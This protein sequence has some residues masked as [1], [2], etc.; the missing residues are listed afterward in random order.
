MT[1]NTLDEQLTKYLTDVHSI[2]EQALIQ[3]R[4]APDIAADPQLA[5][6][7]EQHCHETEGQERAVRDR[8]EARDAEPSKLKDLPGKAGGLAFVLFARS[9]PD[10]AGKLTTH[11]FSYEAMELAAYELLTRV[12]DRAGD[13]ET[14]A[15]AREIAA[16]EQ[17]MMD[18][19]EGLF[20]TAVDASLGELEPDDLSEQLDKYLSD[21]HAIEAQAIELLE[22]GPEIAGDEQIA[23]LYVEHLRETREHQRLVAER[24]EARGA[25]P[26]NLKDAAMRMGALNWGAF[27][28]AQP[29]TPGKLVAFAYAFEHLEIGAYEQLRRVAARA[30]DRET[31]DLAERILTEERAAAQKLSGLFDRAIEASL[32]AVGARS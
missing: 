15:M 9:Q 3:L 20:D 24:L 8:L 6:A 18:R 11:A 10:T 27:F 7:F 16:Q 25:E 4:R 30:G 2:E 14:G 13:T 22:K 32:E 29:D 17:T 1:E 31:S 28:Q 26:S 21:A 5:E 12:A 19:L 23:Q